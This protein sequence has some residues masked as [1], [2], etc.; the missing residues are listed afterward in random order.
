MPHGH[1]V[2]NAKDEDF[3]QV[4]VEPVSERQCCAQTLPGSAFASLQQKTSAT[5]VLALYLAAKSF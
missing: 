5:M 1:L 3:A 2:C 4:I